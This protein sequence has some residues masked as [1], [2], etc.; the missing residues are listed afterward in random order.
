MSYFAHDAIIVTAYDDDMAVTIQHF[1]ETMPEGL[2]PLLAGPLRA[3]VD[4]Y[5]TWFFA[6]DCGPEGQGWNSDLGDIWRAKFLELFQDDQD[7]FDIVG[8]RYGGDH[9]IE[10]G[11]VIT[12]DSDEGGED[13]DRRAALKAAR[14]PRVKVKFVDYYPRL[15]SCVE[16]WPECSEG[17]YNPHCCRFPKSCSCTV[18]DIET[19]VTKDWLVDE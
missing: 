8:V 18:Y 13:A 3:P 6:P 5:C 15:K 7:S 11:A 19:A 4:C 10:H 2:R 9:G 1:R 16:E 14:A 17:D 12:F